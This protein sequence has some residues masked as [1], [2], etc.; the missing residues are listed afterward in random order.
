MWQLSKK[1]LDILKYFLFEVYNFFDPH[2][3]IC[4]LFIKREDEQEEEKERERER[5]RN[6][7][8]REKHQTR[9]L[10]MCPDWRSILQPFDA[11]DNG[12]ING[13]T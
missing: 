13:A 10:G 7:N 5:E 6:F 11:W 1:S 3:R 2:P 8:V 9:N 4:S 12:P